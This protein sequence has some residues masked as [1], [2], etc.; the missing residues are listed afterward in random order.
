MW[1]GLNGFDP[2]N[3]LVLGGVRVGMNLVTAIS[4]YTR[5]PVTLMELAQLAQQESSVHVVK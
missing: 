3:D 5:V 1:A 2:R 4:G